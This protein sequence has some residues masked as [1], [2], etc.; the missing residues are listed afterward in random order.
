M[1]DENKQ[2][3]VRVVTGIEKSFQPGK[4]AVAYSDLVFDEEGRLV[5]V[6]QAQRQDVG[7]DAVAGF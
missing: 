2:K 1:A 5:E 6:K 3:T 4:L 7:V